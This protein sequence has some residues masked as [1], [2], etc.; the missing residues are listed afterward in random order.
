MLRIENVT[1][2]F[3]HGGEREVLALDAVH[4]AVGTGSFAMLVG[5][6]GSGKST[7]L[8]VIT[9]FCF[10]D[11]G[12][13]FLGEI[14]VSAMPAHQRARNVTRIFQARESGLPR[15]M[16]VFE[17][18]RLA[19]EARERTARSVKA[20]HSEIK[21]SLESIRN[22][23]SNVMPEQVWNL[24]GG[25]HQLVNLA[26]ATVLAGRESNRKHVLLLDEHV[27][28]LDPGA[29]E[30]VMAATDALIARTRVAA[31]MATHDCELA[32][33]FGNRQIVM[34]HG[35]VFK[36]LEEGCRMRSPRMLSD[37]IRLAS[38]LSS[39]SG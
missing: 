33:R 10:P 15:A 39:S 17:I 7:L 27:S 38:S 14:D 4:L 24:S 22:G 11:Q 30:T 9:G 25:E 18:L 20:C 8:N 32:T 12:K 5:E 23:L 37:L 35:R 2:R 3:N 36:D 13:V 29:R 21:S 31:I 16:T 19:I 26:V 6:N 34:G 28:Q 1:K